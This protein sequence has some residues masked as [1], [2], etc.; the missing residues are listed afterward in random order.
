MKRFYLLVIALFLSIGISHAYIGSQE[1]ISPEFIKNEGYSAEAYRVMHV[2]LNPE[3]DR[4]ETAQKKEKN[5][6]VHYL[7]KV[8]V[9]LDP[10][11]D[12]KEFAKEEIKFDPTWDEI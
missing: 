2:K 8:Y 11:A 1:M 5:K 3:Q 6:F 9:Y 12:N 7:R 10:Y 4:E